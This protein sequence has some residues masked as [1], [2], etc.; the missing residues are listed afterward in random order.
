[1]TGSYANHKKAKYR[2]ARSAVSFE[3]PPPN[4][5][6]S[7]VTISAQDGIIIVQRNFTYAGATE[8]FFYRDITDAE[9]NATIKTGK[10]LKSKTRWDHDVLKVTTLHEGITTVERYSLAGDG[11]M[12][13][14]VERTGRPAETQY[15]Q[16]Q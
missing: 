15:F 2:E 1:M 10:D 16:H 12:V 9:N 11:S 3:A 14:H 8:T 13:L 5:S 4:S 7:T 6:R